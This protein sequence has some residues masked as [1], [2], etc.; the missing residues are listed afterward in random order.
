MEGKGARTK[1]AANR[2]PRRDPQRK[3][4]RKRRTKNP[5]GNSGNFFGGEGGTDGGNDPFWARKR[6]PK[7]FLGGEK[8]RPFSKKERNG[9]EPENEKHNR[10]KGGRSWGF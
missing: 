10:T 1:N 5:G 6:S 4:E 9:E 7:I 3:N 8:T 2:G